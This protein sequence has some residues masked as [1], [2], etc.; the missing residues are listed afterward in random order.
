M[1]YLAEK[2]K[3]M[4]ARELIEALQRGDE[5]L[6]REVYFALYPSEEIDEFQRYRV[7]DVTF[8]PD[9]CSPHAVDWHPDYVEL[10]TDQS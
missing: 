10:G 7:D 9:M 5:Y 4:T 8:H 6:D 1:Y 2:H 3:I